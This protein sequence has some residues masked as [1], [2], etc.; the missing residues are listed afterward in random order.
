MSD[1]AMDV[2]VAAYQGV[3]TAHKDLDGV[4]ELVRSK[5]LKVEGVILVAHE[6]DDSVTL[7][8]TGDHAGRKGLGWGGGC[9]VGKFADH[10]LKSGLH[11]KMGEALPPVGR[12]RSFRRSTSPKDCS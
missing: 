12:C 2:L 9:V 3:D 6:K 5:Q 1:G 10:K 4:C 7:L 11:D 8:D